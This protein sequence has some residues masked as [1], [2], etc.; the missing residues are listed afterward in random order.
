MSNVKLYDYRNED[1]VYLFT[2]E[3]GRLIHSENS[4][5]SGLGIAGY[6]SQIR[7]GILRLQVI[8]VAIYCKEQR[9]LLSIPGL[10]VDLCSN[11]VLGKVRL[12]APFVREFRLTRGD[13]ILYSCS[14]WHSGARVW[15]DDGDIF[16]SVE[17][18][19]ASPEATAGAHRI[20]SARLAGQPFVGE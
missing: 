16:S 13:Q 15:P 20:W 4:D 11:A 12:A 6:A 18:I 3:T 17:R 2:L 5:T 1:V 8:T 10:E 19:T 9:L 7:I 14:Y